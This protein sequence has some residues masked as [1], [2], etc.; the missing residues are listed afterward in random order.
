MLSE[1]SG[2]GICTPVPPGENREFLLLNYTAIQLTE[3]RDTFVSFLR[4]IFVCCACLKVVLGEG[5]EPSL[6]AGRNRGDY[7]VADPSVS[8][9]GALDSNQQANTKVSTTRFTAAFSVLG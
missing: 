1:S 3:I 6:N 7:P 4:R 8:G 2:E 5:F 9:G